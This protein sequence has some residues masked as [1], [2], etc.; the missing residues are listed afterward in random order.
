MS[1]ELPEDASPSNAPPPAPD[2]TEPRRRRGRHSIGA[3]TGAAFFGA[4]SPDAA[5]PDAASPG[6]RPIE[7]ARV[8]ASAL[9][10]PSRWLT[11]LAFAMV[12]VPFGIILGRLVLAP[13]Q[14]LYLPDDLALID[15]HDRRAL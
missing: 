2:A 15:L 3:S 6:A 10:P 9:V 4:A 5:S 7:S 13:G 12:V 8:E 11:V 1:P 14:H